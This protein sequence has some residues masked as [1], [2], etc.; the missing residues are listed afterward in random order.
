MD[1]GKREIKADPLNDSTKDTQGQQAQCD[2][3]EQ[4]AASP[5]PSVNTIRKVQLSARPASSTGREQ[6]I[7]EFSLGISKAVHESYF[8]NRTGFAVLIG[9]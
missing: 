4:K 1:G 5:S 7:G 3:A 2:I 6:V 8:S 9:H